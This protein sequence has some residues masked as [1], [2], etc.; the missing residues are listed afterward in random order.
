MKRLTEGQVPDT[1][2]AAATADVSVGRRQALAALAV[3]GAVAHEPLRAQTGG[4][5]RLILPVSA[6][7]GVDAI[8]RASSKVTLAT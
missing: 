3:A 1:P 2:T 5:V 7:S 8:V 4:T 6:G